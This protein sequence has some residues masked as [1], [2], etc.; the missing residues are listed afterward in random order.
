MSQD[1][2]DDISNVTPNKPVE[3]LGQ[4]PEQPGRDMPGKPFESYMKEPQAAEK[5]GGLSPMD[6][7]GEGKGKGGAGPTMDSLHKQVQQTSNLLGT[8]HDQLGTKNLA[9]KQSQKYL[10]RNKLSESNSEIRGAAEKVG[11]DVGKAPS[12]STRQNP[13]AR[14]LSLITDSQQ[15]L[16][17]AAGKIQ[18]M[19]S[20]GKSLAPGELLLT[21]VKLSKAQQ[22]LEYSSVI[23]SKAIDDIKMIFNIQ[24]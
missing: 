4:E 5:P 1:L 10:L 19:N 15:Q 18:A 12:R 8:V 7:P 13:I 16:G 9:L 21:Q 14:F 3:P 11:V 20:E 22:E 6:L 2:P 24:I 17:A 23:L